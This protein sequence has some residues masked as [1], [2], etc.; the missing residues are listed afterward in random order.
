MSASVC[1]VACCRASPLLANVLRC[2][3]R[4]KLK[5]QLVTVT[6]LMST[7]NPQMALKKK[8][9][10]LMEM[11]TL[12]SMTLATFDTTTLL[13]AE[14]RDADVMEEEDFSHIVDPEDD[15]NEEH[16]SYTEMEREKQ[17]AIKQDAEGVVCCTI[18]E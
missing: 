7:L 9:L 17:W 3:F 11:M 2:L 15:D 18:Q 16:L 8:T 4:T 5:I 1:L 14:K 13:V 10:N 6:T 12:R